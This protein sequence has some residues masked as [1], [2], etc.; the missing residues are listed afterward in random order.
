MDIAKRGVTT[1]S[2]GETK[3][4]EHSS[5]PEQNK[6]HFSRNAISEGTILKIKSS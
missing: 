6:G 3:M 2:K 4:N 5:M 1:I